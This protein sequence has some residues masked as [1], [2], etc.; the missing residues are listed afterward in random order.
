M[1]LLLERLVFP[2]WRYALAGLVV[3]IAGGYFFFGHSG[4]LGATFS[5]APGDFKEQVRVSGTVTAAKD[6]DLGFAT[7]GR[8]SGTYVKVGQHV[9]AGTVIAE[10]ENGDLI[11][12]L[13]Q[14]RSALDEAQANLASLE[15]GTRP[16]ELA[17]A[18]TAVTSAEAALVDAVQSA[19]TA[20]DDAVHN[21]ADTLFANPRTDP[22][23]TFNTSAGIKGTVEQ[24]RVAIEP[25][26]TN[27]AQLIGTL[28]TANV[29]DIAKR[30]QMYLMQVKAF[31]ADMNLTINQGFPDTTTTTATLSSYSTTLATARTNVNTA[32]TALTTNSTALDSAKK[33]LLLK[34]AGSTNESI[35]A[36]QAAVA[37]AVADVENAHAAIT[38]TRVV[39]PFSGTVTRM[40]A[41]VGEIVSPTAS[42]IGMQSDGLFQVETFVPEVTIARVAVGNPATTT[43]DAYGSSITFS[44]TVVA[45]DPAETVKDGVPTYKT[46][47]SF[48]SADSRIRSG[49]TA[50]VVMETGVLRNA[51]VIPAGA[52]G[53]KN[54][55]SYVSIVDK[56]TAT[57][58]TVTTGPSPAVGQAEIRSGLSA[59]DT[60]L[61]APVP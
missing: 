31:L 9:G 16:E 35:A 60:I 32:A 39:A 44:T 12:M 47:L 25:V 18:S 26:F 22:K 40:D 36:K 1:R 24:G 8:I 23:L 13:A 46:T 42:L 5:I 55:V 34:Q 21:K 20:S 53:T 59:G 49:M 37:A 41:K 51:I 15:A 27:W 7:S 2:G 19:Y 38:K 52:I 57:A 4:N 58:R 10:T 11:A 28:S 33:N 29:A 14:K 30:S 3:V 43:L 56:G 54:G 6:V 48:L 61:L 17:V 50:D 45:V